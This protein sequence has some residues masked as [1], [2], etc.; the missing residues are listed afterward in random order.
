[1]VPPDAGDRAA[2]TTSLDRATPCT[3]TPQSRCS[4]ICL[5]VRTEVSRVTDEVTTAL[6]PMRRF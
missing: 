1:V 5:L 6:S 4:V 2:G 3:Q